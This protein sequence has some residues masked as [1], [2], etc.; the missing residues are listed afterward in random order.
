MDSVACLSDAVPVA[1][2]HNISV[3]GKAMVGEMNPQSK[4]VPVFRGT[5]EIVADIQI[6]DL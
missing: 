4:K 3:E 5:W 1:E 2:R 6:L